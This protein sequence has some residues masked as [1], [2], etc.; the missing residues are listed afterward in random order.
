[1]A[2]RLRKLRIDEISLVDKPANRRSFSLTKR[3]EGEELTEA[4]TEAV[5]EGVVRRLAGHAFGPNSVADV[6]PYKEAVL[7]VARDLGLFEDPDDEVAFNLEFGI[8]KVDEHQHI[9]GGVVY[10]PDTVDVQGDYI[11]ADDLREAAHWFMENSQA[12]KLMHKGARI[13]AKVLESYIVQRAFAEGGQEIPEGAWYLKLRIQDEDA[14]GAVKSGR[15][16]GFSLGGM[17]QAV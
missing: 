17:A 10:E 2:R 8:A 3:Q 13:A 7:R 15:L 12:V 6:Q 14:W 5:F 4:D 1:M 11:E 16:T 9:V